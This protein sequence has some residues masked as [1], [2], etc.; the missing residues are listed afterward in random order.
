VKRIAALLVAVVIVAAGAAHGTDRK[1]LRSF[2]LSR[3]NDF[4]FLGAD[5]EDE[6]GVQA[7]FGDLDG[8][9]YDDVILGAHLADGRNNSR[10]NAGEV[11]VFFGEPTGF[12]SGSWENLSVIYG[13]SLGSRIGSALDTGDFNGDAIPDLLIGARYS[14]GPVDSLRVRAGEAFLLLGG[15]KG[16]GKKL[17]DLRYEPDITFIGRFPR[18]RLGRRILVTDLDDDGKDDLVMA[19]VGSAGIDT[20]T[21]DAGAVYIVYGDRQDRMRGIRDFSLGEAAVLHGADE[22]DGLGGALASGDWNG[23]GWVDLF[24]GCS[25]ADGP[26][27]TRTNAGE[28]Y[29]LFGEG[30]GRLS[31]EEVLAEGA[32]FTVYG[33]DPYD[34]AGVSVACGDFDGDGIDDLVLGAHL[35]DGPRD[36]RDN[37]G[38]VYVLFGNRAVGTGEMVDLQ[39]EAGIT[40]YG[41]SPGDQLGSITY[42]FDWNEDDYDDLVAVSL[43]NDGPGER[44]Q[45]AGMIYLLR[46]GSQADLHPRVDLSV[47]DGDLRLLGP[48]AQDRIATVLGSIRIG[49]RICLLAGTMLGDGPNDSRLEAGEVYVLP[50]KPGDLE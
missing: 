24:F 42:V 43:L 1:E 19:A 6:L 16:D 40:M 7:R 4:R 8:D 5:M 50:W 48:S 22:S 39:A 45:D 28:T 15:S 31:G 21:R 20:E 47:E 23:D 36:R 2:D 25:F 10:V 46:G 17:V 38:E 18:D 33:A 49:G 29:V 44:R 11:Y 9:G 34:G 37:C 30:G 27:N 3:V 12:E 32:V 41:A 35:G 13:D 26:A 14:D